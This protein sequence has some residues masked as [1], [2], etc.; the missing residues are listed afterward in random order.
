[1]RGDSEGDFGGDGQVVPMRDGGMVGLITQPR[2]RGM[3]PALMAEQQRARTEIEAALTIAAHRPRDQKLALDRILTSCQRPGLAAKAKYRYSRGGTD[4]VGVTIDLMEV[5]AQQWGNLDFG[6]REL[7]RFPGQDGGP[8]E[9]IVEAFAWDMETNVKRKVQFTVQHA[10]RTK[11]GMRIITDPRDI[12]EWVANQAQ[13]RVRTCLENIIPRDVIEMAGDQ[14]EDTMKANVGDIKAAVAKLVPAFAQFGVTPEMIEARLQRRLDTISAAQV[15]YLRTIWTGMRDGVSHPEDWFDMTLGKSP[16]EETPKTTAEKAKD[17]MK[18]RS[19]Q[20]PP[21][22]NVVQPESSQPKSSGT[23][24]AASPDPATSKKPPVAPVATAGEA[25]KDSA[26]DGDTVQEANSD[27]FYWNG[28]DGE[29]ATDETSASENAESAEPTVNGTAVDT[30]IEAE[31]QRY[32]REAGKADGLTSLKHLKAHASQNEIL[33]AS[34]SA[35]QA[36]F[37]TIGAAEDVIRRSR[38]GRGNG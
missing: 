29:V 22:S 20:K 27:G 38:G 19:G 9:S 5:V 7:A 13:R 18:K 37:E 31:I 26:G 25:T 23:P 17:A 6:F 36:V 8:G 30:Q 2:D 34:P 28:D 3:V 16:E 11:K 12:Y 4:I 14:A 24:V 15:V 1:M 35:M 21:E 10:E 33:K 32:A